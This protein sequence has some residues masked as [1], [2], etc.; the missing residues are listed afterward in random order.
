MYR[1]LIASVNTFIASL[2]LEL[3]PEYGDEFAYYR[4]TKE[5]AYTFFGEDLSHFMTNLRT[6]CDFA[7]ELSPFVWAVLHEVGHHFTQYV[8]DDPDFDPLVTAFIKQV[9]TEETFRAYFFL[10]EEQAAT[11]WAIDFVTNN[12]DIISSTVEHFNI[13]LSI[14]NQLDK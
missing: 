6:I 10:P 2:D 1:N 11:N 14:D 7:D 4:G 13:A 8:Y 9:N 12:P 3:V 5:V